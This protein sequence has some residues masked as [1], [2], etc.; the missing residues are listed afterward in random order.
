MHR[1]ETT[2]KSP[3]RLE[4]GLLDGEE[5]YSIA[6]TFDQI[7]P[8]ELDHRLDVFATDVRNGALLEATRARYAE[9][10]LRLADEETRHRYFEKSDDNYAVVPDIRRL[11]TFR[12]VNLLD[13][14]FWRGVVDRYDLIVCTNLLQHLHSA[15]VRRM[16]VCAGP[17]TRLLPYGCSGRGQTRRQCQA[18]TCQRGSVVLP[19]Y[20]PSQLSSA[21]NQNATPEIDPGD[22]PL[23][24]RGNCRAGYSETAAE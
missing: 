2:R 3:A 20:S 1:R 19:A 18:Q 14:L 8:P 4:R 9:A 16:A 12:R 21:R 17:A 7:K 6:I 13:D 24:R 10:A 5:A 15:A 11:V 22:H 23:L